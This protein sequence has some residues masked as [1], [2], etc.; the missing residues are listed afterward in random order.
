MLGLALGVLIGALS[1]LLLL[2]PNTVV[3]LIHEFASPSAIAAAS[4]CFSFVA[5]TFLGMPDSQSNIS[6][7]PSHKLVSG[8]HGNK[9]LKTVALS[10]LIAAIAVAAAS[11]L[12]LPFY[13]MFY[14]AMVPYLFPA[15]LLLTLLLFAKLE[16]LIPNAIA[17]AISGIFGALVL[18]AGLSEPLMPLFTGLFAVPSLLF[19]SKHFPKQRREG[20]EFLPAYIIVGA[21]LGAVA[22]VLPAFNS[23][24]LIT[25]L[26][27]AAISVSTIEFLALSSSVSSATLFA[28]ILMHSATGKARQGFLAYETPCPENLIY[29]L[30]SF[31]ACSAVLYLISERAG[32]FFSA[33]NMEKLRPFILFYLIVV[34]YALSGLGGVLAMSGAAAIGS[35]CL[36]LGAERRFLMGSLLVPTLMLLACLQ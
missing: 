20:A 31:A 11:P 29:A 12:L 2:H 30:A 35:F 7:L 10:S 24:S 26:A 18:N 3:P 16:K 27:S 34:C 36:K 14:K 13:E 8:G 9:A 5:S 22:V 17:F 28:S 6:M 1:A 23:P 32:R 15:V 4:L 25:A 19:A 33:L 21:L